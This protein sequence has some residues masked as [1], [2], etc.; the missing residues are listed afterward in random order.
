MAIVVKPPQEPNWGDVVA[1]RS[2]VIFAA[3]SIEQG[4]AE[5]WQTKL[6]AD[7]NEYENVVLLNPRRDEWDSSMEQSADNPT[8]KAQVEWELDGI[9]LADLVIFYFDPNTKSPI[10]LLELGLL[11]GMDGTI[12]PDVLVCC[13]PGYWRRGNVEIVCNRY[14]FPLLRSYDELIGRL[15]PIIGERNEI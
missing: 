2:F 15:K 13:P 6:A 1:N 7:L 14:K 12:A 9:S 5:D 4:S 10:T 11:A 8:F 3:G